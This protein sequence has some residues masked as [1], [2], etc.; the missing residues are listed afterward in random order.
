[1]KIS[2]GVIYGI[3]ARLVRFFMITNILIIAVLSYKNPFKGLRS[4]KR[5]I[6]RR[7]SVQGLPRIR[8]YI[9]GGHRFFISE[10]IPGWPSSAFNGFVRAEVKRSLTRKVTAPLSTV[11]FAVTSKCRLRCPHCY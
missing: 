5:I 8:K 1:M 2:S 11:I 10:N 7:E 4:L 3:R 6:K 9:K